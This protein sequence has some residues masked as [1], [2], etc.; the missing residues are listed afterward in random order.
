MLNGTLKKQFSKK[1]QELIWFGLNYNCDHIF[2]FMVY[3]LT[4]RFLHC[5]YIHKFESAMPEHASEHHYAQHLVLIN[6][7]SEIKWKKNVQRLTKMSATSHSHGSFAISN[8]KDF[9]MRAHKKMV[10]IYEIA[11]CHSWDFLIKPSL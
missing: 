11:S 5:K 1:T 3:L 7:E 8:V 10:T 6:S 9:V 4:E 2:A